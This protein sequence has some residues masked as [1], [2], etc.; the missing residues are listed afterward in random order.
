MTSIPV[1]LL[2]FLRIDSRDPN[3]TFCIVS[4]QRSSQESQRDRIRWQHGWQSLATL[5][6]VQK[7]PEKKVQKKE[8]ACRSY[9]TDARCLSDS[10][11]SEEETCWSRLCR[12]LLPLPLAFLFQILSGKYRTRSIKFKSFLDR[13]RINSQSCSNVDEFNRL[14]SSRLPHQYLTPLPHPANIFMEYPFGL[15]H[16]VIPPPLHS[17]PLAAHPTTQ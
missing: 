3:S 13:N 2:Y 15:H 7:S 9:I 1:R 10:I 16:R 11:S 17:L 4:L 12:L 14:H 8:D 5:P 6:V